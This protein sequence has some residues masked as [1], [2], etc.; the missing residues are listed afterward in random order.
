MTLL[1]PWDSQRPHFPPTHPDLYSHTVRVGGVVK[2]FSDVDLVLKINVFFPLQP[3]LSSLLLFCWMFWKDIFLEVF[4][5]I[6]LPVSEVSLGYESPC[7]TLSGRLRLEKLAAF[8]CQTPAISAFPLSPR[9]V[10]LPVCS[11]MA[12]ARTHELA[13][14]SERIVPIWN[15]QRSRKYFPNW[16]WLMGWEGGDLDEGAEW[17]E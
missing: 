13:C 1:P 5:A 9:L 7:G 11:D 12:G 17:E 6:Y 15:W 3:P 10:C 16:G 8:L 2:L 4:L 14:F